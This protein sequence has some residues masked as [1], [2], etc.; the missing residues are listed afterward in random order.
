M[1][2]QPAHKDA[3]SGEHQVYKIDV[4]VTF[5]AQRSV[6]GTSAK[7]LVLD[8]HVGTCTPHQELCRLDMTTPGNDVK[9]RITVLQSQEQGDRA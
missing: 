6:E 5:D 8:A 9:G 3:G 7:Y 2:C 1:F 4:L